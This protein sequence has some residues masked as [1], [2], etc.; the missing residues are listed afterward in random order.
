MRSFCM[1]ENFPIENIGKEFELSVLSLL[2]NLILSDK[3][4]QNFPFWY[5]WLLQTI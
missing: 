3:R 5:Q 1:K 4:N 2:A